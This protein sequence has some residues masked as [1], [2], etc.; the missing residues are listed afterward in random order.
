MFTLSA[1]FINFREIALSIDSV[2]YWFIK[3]VYNLL[4]DIASMQIFTQG[5]INELSERVYALIGIFMLF[6]LTLSMITYVVNPDDFSDKTKGFG[7]MIKNVII[8]L[9][10]IV[11]TPY[12]FAEAFELQDMVLKQNVLQNLV[13]GDKTSYNIDNGGS[14]MQFNL[15][16]QFVKP[17][18]DDFPDLAAC[19]N[20]YELNDEGTGYKPTIVSTGD[21]AGEESNYNY[22]FNNECYNALDGKI[23]KKNKLSLELYKTA[24]ET[25]NY[26]ILTS[27]SA[28]D[29]YSIEA[30]TSNGFKE[31]II[32]YSWPLT[33][34]TGAVTLLILIVFCIDIATRSLKLAFYQI[35]APIPIISYCDPK[36]AK[37]GMFKKWT[38]ACISTYLEL[39]IR[40]VGLYLGMFVI[41]LAVRD[42]KFNGLAIIFIII[43]ALI[44]AKQ[45]PKI[46][47]DL[48]G[49]KMDGKFTLNPFKKISE[50]ALGAKK[51]SGILGGVAGGFLA[52]AI[53]GGKGFFDRVW[54]AG[55][56]AIRG[57][58]GGKGFGA[59]LNTQADVNRKIR[60]ARINGSSFWGS[61]G[62][63]MGSKFGLDYATLEKQSLEY[64]NNKAKYDAVAR[65]VEQ[66]KN[67]YS[68]RKK[69]IQKGMTDRNRSKAA[70]E[71]ITNN[72]KNIESRAVDQ[73]KTGAAGV[74]SKEYK[75][76]LAHFEKLKLNN[77]SGYLDAN[78]NVISKDDARLS[79]DAN[80][81]ARINA[82][83]GAD[84][85]YTGGSVVRA[86]TDTDVAKA[87]ISADHYL[88]E[89]A[90]YDYIS[91]VVA[92]SKGKT[93]Y[94]D[95]DGND[96][97]IDTSDAGVDDKTLMNSY[98]SYEEAMNNLGE[99]IPAENGH[100]F[101][102]NEGFDRAAISVTGK[103]IHKQFGQSKGIIGAIDRSMYSDN[104]KIKEIDDEI[105]KLETETKTEISGYY[106]DDAGVRRYSDNLTYE[107]AGKHLDSVKKELDHA[108]AVIKPNY[109]SASA[110]RISK[111]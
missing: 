29:I 50:E 30:T 76:R 44:F 102:E 7:S 62:A 39:F 80:G 105:T 82:I 52:G 99:P 28:N 5:T 63:A 108:K 59:G 11:L 51:A 103:D 31:K 17:N 49:I 18:I 1:S 74:F 25:S 32:K 35:I 19:K 55:T 101:E 85:K 84:G 86:I 77:G 41:L 81:T 53:G 45:L 56:G 88:N 83:L 109:D 89:E 22:M 68:V 111:K 96:Q 20:I 12:I 21:S 3:A 36:S 107:Q 13:F 42:I 24:F 98:K 65:S 60:D 57:G 54:N 73:I 48:T 14:I 95:I 91:R 72:A 79:I 78:N 8:S 38:K 43:G 94:K 106:Y 2:I 34:I 97:A 23:D 4:V 75:A 100:S 47:T 6:K 26:S 10:L 104:D 46:I 90:K 67:G 92:A 61:V 71:R 33:T 58:V 27:S 16:S 69:E 37:D 64:E 15:F 110:T 40:L 66:K 9:I 87:E 70:F 93:T